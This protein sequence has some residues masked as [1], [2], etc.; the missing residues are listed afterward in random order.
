MF[1]LF[2][3]HLFV[4]QS[5]TFCLGNMLL[6][7]FQEFLTFLEHRNPLESWNFRFIF[8][9]C[10]YIWRCRNII[11][12]LWFYIWIIFSFKVRGSCAWLWFRVVI[13]SKSWLPFVLRLSS[14]RRT[15]SSLLMKLNHIWIVNHCRIF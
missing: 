12:G 6:M 10:Y 7:L 5:I 13:C 8:F 3:L 2:L 15:R 14:F 4:V 9:H 11:F 1:F